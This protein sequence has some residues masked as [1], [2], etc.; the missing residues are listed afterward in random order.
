MSLNDEDRK[1]LVKYQLE[2]AEDFYAKA[3]RIAQSGDWDTAA[4]RLYYSL[5]HA[6]SALL[7]SDGIQKKTHKG[8]INQIHMHYVLTG[9]LDKEE[10]RLLQKMFTLRHEGDYEVFITVTEEDINDCIPPVRALLDKLIALNEMA[11]KK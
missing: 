10:G 5:Y 3:L 2:K 7:L 11:Q 9:K 6:A 1:I 8:F 4:N